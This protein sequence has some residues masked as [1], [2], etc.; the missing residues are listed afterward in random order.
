M[1]LD[2]PFPLPQATLPRPPSR[3][4]RTLPPSYLYLKR[5]IYYFRYALSAQWQELLQHAEIRISLRTSYRRPAK[6]RALLLFAELTI[7]LAGGQM[8]TYQEIRRRLNIL[9]QR[10]LAA[11]AERFQPRTINFSE[12][13]LE[14]TPESLH[15]GMRWMY[16][17]MYGP[18]ES[19]EQLADRCIPALIEQG[20][21]TA[22]EISEGDRPLIAKAMAE[23]ELSYQDI[24]RKKEAGDFMADH[25]IMTADYGPLRPVMLPVQPET[26]PAAPLY[27][28]ALERYVAAK[29][30]DGAWKQHG[31]ADHKQRLHTF[32]D[33]KGDMPLDAISRDDMREFRETLRKLPPNHSR[34]KKYAGMSAQEII[35]T[36]PEK[37]L[38][39]ATVN[40]IV[41]A[42]GSLLGW[43]A[44]E[45]I[46][47]SNPAKGL[48]IKDERQ[49]IELR[50]AF[51]EDDLKRIFA[52]P[53]F[54]EGK[55][56]FADY[57]WIP[58]I[59]LYSGMRLEEIAQMHCAD[60]YET[61]TKGLWVF[62]LNDNGVDEAGFKKTLKNKNARRTVPLH[63]ALIELGLL[64]YHER[65]VK[66]GVV[67]LFPELK[68]TERIGKY[69]K[70]PGKQF[71]AI[72]KE[73][74]GTG[75]NKSFH[76]LRH[77]FADY[78]KQRGMQKDIFHQLYGHDIAALAAKQYGSK[79]PPE[80]CY[81]EVISKFG[82]SLDVAG[83]RECAR[84]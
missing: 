46:L 13:G 7:I 19:F 71:N 23:M 41:E 45:G 10:F 20:I 77:T 8:I 9:L 38:N 25:A 1:T 11:D 47:Q 57:F 68:K 40:I 5:N 69:G 30:T 44:Q 18:K 27:T 17:R 32:L 70:Q 22:D 43:F 63:S 65:M 26:R 49:A 75:A 76:S 61:T 51:T 3:S 4:S 60:V 62:D 28:E 37:Q 73:V 79:F 16:K 58:L 64:D 52:H 66:S 31:V 78:F 53:K 39:I 2:T 81:E 33:I 82:V 14:L 12:A 6:A 55:F 84:K 83:L 80:R 72:V 56:K 74:L 34:S 54:T 50:E 59:G 35:R 42:V 24:L 21:F 29:I 67:R 15:A 36:Q 48:Q